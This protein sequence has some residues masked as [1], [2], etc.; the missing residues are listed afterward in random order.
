MLYFRQ[1]PMNTSP[2][3]SPS[4]LSAVGSLIALVVPPVLSAIQFWKCLRRGL[5]AQAAAFKLLCI[6]G[7][8]SVGALAV[9]ETPLE[10]AKA[11]ALYATC[12]LANLIAITSAQ[13][14]AASRRR[15]A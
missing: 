8:L 3:T 14:A 5:S 1:I 12:V 9:A 11:C 15:A 13:T 6:V 4:F 2:S 10:L 7:L